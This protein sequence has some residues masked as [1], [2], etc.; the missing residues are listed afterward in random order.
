MYCG[1]DYLIGHDLMLQDLICMA[2]PHGEQSRLLLRFSPGLLRKHWISRRDVAFHAS[3]SRQVL[4]TLQI[5]RVL[6]DEDDGSLIANMMHDCSLYGG[7][8]DVVYY[9]EVGVLKKYT[10][11]EGLLLRTLS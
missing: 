1:F 6:S 9:L 10:S 4:D 2:V 5:L 8:D 11:G 3:R 7:F